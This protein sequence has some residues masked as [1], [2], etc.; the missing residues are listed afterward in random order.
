MLSLKQHFGKTPE[1]QKTED[2]SKNKE[3]RTVALLHII[4][5]LGVH[6]HELI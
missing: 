6:K 2:T 4:D 5:I 3:Q 1:C